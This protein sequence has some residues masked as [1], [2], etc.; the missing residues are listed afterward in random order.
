MI[1]Q[2][3]KVY[4]LME[5][6]LRALLGLKLKEKIREVKITTSTRPGFE[7]KFLRADVIIDR[8]DKGHAITT[9]EWT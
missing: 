4:R 2:E 6:G 7:G 8:P 3:T 5:H 1:T 9:V